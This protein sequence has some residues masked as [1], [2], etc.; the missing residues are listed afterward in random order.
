MFGI[1]FVFFVFF[2]AL[3]A[4]STQAEDARYVAGTVGF[5]KYPGADICFASLSLDGLAKGSYS[6]TLTYVPCEKIP[7]DKLIIVNYEKK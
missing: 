6:A 1:M 2:G 7:A 4:C 3:S 5:L